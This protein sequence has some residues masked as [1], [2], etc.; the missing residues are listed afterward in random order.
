MLVIPTHVALAADDPELVRAHAVVRGRLRAVTAGDRTAPKEG[1][2][3]ASAPYRDDD[4]TIGYVHVFRVEL[5]G[6]AQSIGIPADAGWW[7]VAKR[8]V[9]PRRTPR[10]ATLR[11]VS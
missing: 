7:P 3:L 10:R 5:L 1:E 6:R 9:A 8:S 11:L 2:Y 4:G